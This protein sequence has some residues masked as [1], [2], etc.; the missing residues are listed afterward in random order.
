MNHLIKELRAR[1]ILD[2]RG[3][4][5]VEVDC[6]LDDG[7]VGRASVPSGASTGKHEVVE[8]RDNN[9]KRYGG[10]GVQTAVRNV[11][12]L[13][14]LLRGVDAFDQDAVDEAMIAGDGTE[15]KSRLGANAILGVSMAVLKAHAASVKLPLYRLIAQL[16]RPRQTHWTMPV[17]MMN[18]IN[19]GAHADFGA[20]FQE[21][22]ILPV[23]AKTMADAVRMG[24]EVF[25]TLK[26]VLKKK[27]LNTGVGD[28]GGFAPTVH[29]NSDAPTMIMKAITL[30]GYKPGKDIALGLDAA[31]S[32]FFVTG[33]KEIK[34]RRDKE[35]GYYDLKRDDKKMNSL[36]L[37]KYYQNWVKK[38]PFVTIEDPL[39]ED[40]WQH[41]P[42]FTNTL[43]KQV[44]VVG[45][46]IFVTNTRLLERGI[47]AGAANAILIKVNQIGTITETVRA[48]DMAA[49]AGWHAIV[50]HR[51][52]ETEDTTIADLVVGLGTGQIKT[53][54]L[55]RTE[56]TAKYNQLMRIEEDL[57]KKAYYPGREAL[58]Y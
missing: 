37:I 6:V 43:G 44:Q 10:K 20:D 42:E 12:A 32:E 50:S 28:E 54:S 34:T 52:G 23:G 48:V 41:W 51:S 22:M 14:R 29:R 27:G 36:Q 33:D 47:A 31:A 13:A 3:N 56:R 21:F 45:D 58:R 55:S 39:S 57:G 11:T 19:G 4:P 24:A 7:S 40:D 1:E 18:I 46:D 2:S 9:P 17:P 5:T 15:N 26:G 16:Y 8:L 49:R 30:A 35:G 38:F 25:H 53:G